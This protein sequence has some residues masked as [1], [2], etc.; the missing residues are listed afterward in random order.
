M[1]QILKIIKIIQIT[2]K[3]EPICSYNKG[4]PA[5]PKH[6]VPLAENEI[7]HNWIS[8]LNFRE[9]LAIWSEHSVPDIT[10]NINNLRVLHKTQF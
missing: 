3:E 1:K 8:E 2:T 6:S 4:P 7:P 9:L 10:W 5:S